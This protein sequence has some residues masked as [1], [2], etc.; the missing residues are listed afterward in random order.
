MS[1]IRAKITD[2]KS[3]E[4]LNIVSFDF[5]GTS[6]TMM[7]LELKEEVQIGKEVL[8]GVKATSIAIG[9][10][11][12]GEI[13]YSNQI[14][15]TIQ[16]IEIGQLLCTISLK[17]NDTLFESVITASSAQR[18]KLKKDDKVCAFIKASEISILKILDA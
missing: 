13:S 6:L 15:S 18:L 5:F 14:N 11:F 10:D 4:S 17:A 12:V 8:L 2:I 1:Q 3:Y 7:S 9:K 16:D